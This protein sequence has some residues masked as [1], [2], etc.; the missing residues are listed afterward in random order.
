MFTLL[1]LKEI[2]FLLMLCGHVKS[3]RRRENFLL[4]GPC[5][6]TPLVVGETVDP[7]TGMPLEPSAL[8]D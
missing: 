6:C 2:A 4:G 7:I 5:G 1:L 8:M 3:T